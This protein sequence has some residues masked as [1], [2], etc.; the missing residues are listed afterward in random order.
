MQLKMAWNV[1][2]VTERRGSTHGRNEIQELRL[3]ELLV[4]LI[5]PAKAVPDAG[6]SPSYQIVPNV[7]DALRQKTHLPR[8]HFG[9]YCNFWT[10]RT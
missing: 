2:I 10:K 8:W 3:T 9:G 4:Y 1:P 5:R 6:Q 7:A